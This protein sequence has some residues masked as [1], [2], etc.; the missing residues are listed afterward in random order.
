MNKLN[1]PLSTVF[2]FPPESNLIQDLLLLEIL[3]SAQLDLK[4]HLCQYRRLNLMISFVDFIFKF[5]IG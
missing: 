2:A 5:I 3:N 1:V 4:K